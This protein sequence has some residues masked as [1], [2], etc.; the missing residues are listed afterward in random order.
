MRTCREKSTR[1]PTAS[2]TRERER[3]GGGRERE[4]E[5][6]ILQNSGQHGSIQTSSGILKRAFINPKHSLVCVLLFLA[7]KYSGTD[8]SRLTCLSG[9]SG[10]GYSHQSILATASLAKWLRRPPRKRKIRSS[11]PACDGIFP[12]RVIPM[13]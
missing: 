12:S 3:E 7:H 11:S 8:H 1:R 13:T 6:E 5:R 2:T 4:R 10:T 9:N